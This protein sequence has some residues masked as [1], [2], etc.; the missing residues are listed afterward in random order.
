MS[1]TTKLDGVTGEKCSYG[2]CMLSGDRVYSEQRVEGAIIIGYFCSWDHMVK[3]HDGV[4]NVEGR[5]EW[6]KTQGITG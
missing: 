5:R 3:W 4:M 1:D 2:Y 6:L